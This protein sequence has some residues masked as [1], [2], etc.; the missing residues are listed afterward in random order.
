MIGKDSKVGRGLGKLYCKVKREGSGCVLIG[1]CWR[2]EAVCGQSG[3]G[4][5]MWLV[6]GDYLP[7]CAGLEVRAKIREP[8]NY[9]LSLGRMGPVAAEG[10]G[11]ASWA[12]CC[13]CVG[14]SA[15]FIDGVAPVGL[16]TESH[17]CCSYHILKTLFSLMIARKKRFYFWSLFTFLHGGYSVS[18]YLFDLAVNQMA[19][20]DSEPHFLYPL[21]SSVLNSAF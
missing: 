12:C 7:F 2:G 13:R 1:G 15:T 5:L 20:Y 4:C 21:Q 10:C 3:C 9:W 8:G 14:Q 16:H 17:P 11:L 19:P 6:R 18:A